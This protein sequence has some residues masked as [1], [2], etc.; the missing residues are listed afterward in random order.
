MNYRKFIL[1]ELLEEKEAEEFKEFLKDIG[2]FEKMSCDKWHVLEISGDVYLD[3]EKI[4]DS[5][6]QTV[7]TEEP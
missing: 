2:V 6:N 4:N 1:A 5:S 3:G 7:T